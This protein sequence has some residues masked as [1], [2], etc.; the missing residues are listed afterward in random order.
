[1]KKYLL[2]MSISFLAAM[3]LSCAS[4]KPATV[5]TEEPAPPPP[6]EEERPPSPEPTIEQVVE[7][8]KGDIILDGAKTH[9]VVWKNT[10]TNI[11]KRYYGNA[12]GYYFPL[13]MLASH[14]AISDPDAIVSGTVLAIP[15][16]RRNLD[17][18]SARQRLKEYLYEIAEVYNDNSKLRKKWGGQSRNHLRALASSL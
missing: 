7:K 15:D 6:A 2:V 3:A 12:N 8:Y 4:R 17:D 9:K 13:I 16:L 10:L 11:A 1:M 14:G 18:P 5:S